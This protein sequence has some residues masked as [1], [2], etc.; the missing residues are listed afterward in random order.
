MI[1]TQET[2]PKFSR[3]RLFRLAN[4]VYCDLYWRNISSLGCIGPNGET[5]DRKAFLEVA[6]KLL[7]DLDAQLDKGKIGRM[8]DR[9]S[10]GS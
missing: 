2:R 1:W 8:I 9:T 5:N 4:V 10:S 6:T 7:D 3:T